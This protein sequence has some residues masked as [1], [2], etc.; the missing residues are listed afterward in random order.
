MDKKKT[1]KLVAIAAAGI[2]LAG[3]GLAVTAGAA[4]DAEMG[5]CKVKNSCKGKGDCGVKD[6]HNCAG[7]NA[8]NGKGWVY[9]KS[10]NKA[11][12][13]TAEDCARIDG[14]TF[15]APKKKG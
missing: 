11:V 3:S 14:S 7:K 15:K 5:K 13:M 8:C 2:F 12:K 6:K 9:I 1:S 10:E 4:Q